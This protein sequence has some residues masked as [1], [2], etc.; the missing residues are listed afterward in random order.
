L[1]LPFFVDPCGKLYL[2]CGKPQIDLWNL[3]GKP[4]ETLGKK[5]V[6]VK[7]F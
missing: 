2:P 5:S 1:K 3:C 4:V 7:N 6:V